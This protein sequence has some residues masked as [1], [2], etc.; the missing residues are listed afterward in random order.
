M[1]RL[2]DSVEI[3][4]DG[5]LTR[6]EYDGNTVSNII[7]YNDPNVYAQDSGNNNTQGVIQKSIKTNNGYSVEIAIPWKTIGIAQGDIEDEDVR[8]AGAEDPW[9]S[10]AVEIFIDEDMTKG[11]FNEHTVQYIV[12]YVICCDIIRV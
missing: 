7:R 4:I 11:P 8:V 9:T 12:R 5:G 6:G 3:F 10:D 1:G 2:D